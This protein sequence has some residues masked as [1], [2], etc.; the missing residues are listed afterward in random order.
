MGKELDS[1]NI[2]PALKESAPEGR[3][4]C[5]KA[6]EL[7]QELGVHPMEIGKTCNSLGIKIVACQLGCFR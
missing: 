4:P 2:E 5:E 3:L 7:A 1:R 6:L